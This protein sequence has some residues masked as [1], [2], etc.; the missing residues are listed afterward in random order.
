MKDA[1]ESGLV[2]HWIECAG[3]E[4]GYDE[5]RNF[6][7]SRPLPK[8]RRKAEWKRDHQIALEEYERILEYDKAGVGVLEFFS[9]SNWRVYAAR[10]GQ[11]LHA[12]T[13][14]PTFMR[15]AVLE[16]TV[17]VPD[18]NHADWKD[19]RDCDMCVMTFLAREEL[20][21]MTA[22]ESRQRKQVGYG[23]LDRGSSSF[24]KPGG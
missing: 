16:E 6:V 5:N 9:G 4:Y 7:E 8:K 13:S 12:R 22:R 23:Q 10:S 17:V 19:M 1:G 15:N 2:T 20:E 24:E 14:C 18:R 11:V 3:E 21:R